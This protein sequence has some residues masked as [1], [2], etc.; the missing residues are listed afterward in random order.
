[1]KDPLYLAQGQYPLLGSD[2]ASLD[3]DKVLLN[4]SVVRESTHGVDVLVGGIVL[5]RGVV[6]DQLLQ[7][8]QL[9]S[10]YK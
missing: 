6:L 3:H 2:A 1:M 8:F 5:G 10:S 7:N 9:K 4:H